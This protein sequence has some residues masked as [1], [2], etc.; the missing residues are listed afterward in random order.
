M[1]ISNLFV[2]DV[3][4]NENTYRKKGYCVISK[5]NKSPNMCFMKPKWNSTYIAAL[6]FKVTMMSSTL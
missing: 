6:S 1:A 2:V 3:I 5:L 4:I